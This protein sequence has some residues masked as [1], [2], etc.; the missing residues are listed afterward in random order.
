METKGTTIFIPMKGVGSSFH[1]YSSVHSHFNIDECRGN[2]TIQ[3]PKKEAT[4]FSLYF[5]PSLCHFTF[6]LWLSLFI[7]LSL[8]LS[9]NEP[10]L[11]IRLLEGIKTKRNKG[12][13]FCACDFNHF[14][15]EWSDWV[16]PKR[17]WSLRIRIVISH[18]PCT[19]AFSWLPWP[20]ENRDLSLLF[21]LF[22]H[23]SSPSSK[24]WSWC[25]LSFIWQIIK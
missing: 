17:R 7:T 18:P 12:Y 20:C 9:P 23:Q 19:P 13:E 11:G 4:K 1:C 24:L 21:G 5:L 2:K 3:R 15:Q 16:P 25:R 6:F 22:N 10:N 14:C 8:S